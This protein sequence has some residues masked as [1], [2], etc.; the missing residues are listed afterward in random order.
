[1]PGRLRDLRFTF[2]CPGR[3]QQVFRSLEHDGL[4]EHDPLG[5]PLGLPDRLAIGASA[6]FSSMESFFAEWDRQARPLPNLAWRGRKRGLAPPFSA[7]S[8]FLA[9]GDHY[10]KLGNTHFPATTA[11][12]FDRFASVDHD[13]AAVAPLDRGWP[14]AEDPRTTSFSGGHYLHGLACAFKGAAGHTRLAHRRWLEHGPWRLLRDEALDLSIVQFHEL[15]APVELAVAQAAPGHALL[16]ATWGSGF[17][18]P[19]RVPQELQPAHYEASSRTSVVVVPP[20][21]TVS[22]RLM[23]EAAAI[24]ANQPYPDTV[25]DQVAFVFLREE[26]ARAELHELWLRGLEVRAITATGERRLDADYQAEPPPPP[27]WV[28]RE[29]DRDGLG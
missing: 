15:D 4:L 21:G 12:I 3:V 10:V 5:S 14:P 2:T 16:G 1:M 22:K 29:Q 8:A 11:L 13:Y 17:L 18:P 24:K 6:N 7:W 25:V 9:G 23:C 26:D 28:K 20:G 19:T 27:D